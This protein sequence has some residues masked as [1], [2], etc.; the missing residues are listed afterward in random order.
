MPGVMRLTLMFSKKPED[1]TAA[2]LRRMLKV[3]PA[4]EADLN[5]HS[6]AL[7][8][9]TVASD[10]RKQELLE[11]FQALKAHDWRRAQK[12]EDFDPLLNAAEAFA[13]KCVSGTLVLLM[14][15]NPF[16]LFDASSLMYSEVLDGESGKELN[17]FIE[18]GAWRMM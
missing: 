18:A 15:R 3:C 5:D 1:A 2:E 17:A 7:F 11:F 8:A 6:Y 12:F 9:T 4:C 14:V 16:E 10:E 13:L